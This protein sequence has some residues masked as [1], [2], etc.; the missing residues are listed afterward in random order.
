MN[1]LQRKNLKS[2]G[3]L[4][5]HHICKETPSAI[6]KDT[7]GVHNFNHSTKLRLE[8]WQWHEFM[9]CCNATVEVQASESF[10]LPTQFFSLLLPATGGGHSLSFASLTLPAGDQCVMSQVSECSFWRAANT[11]QNG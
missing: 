10:E 1:F 2:A 8:C 7:E 9:S 6:L 3:G 11:S 4:V 5:D